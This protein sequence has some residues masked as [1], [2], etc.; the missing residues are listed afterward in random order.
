MVRTM[1]RSAFAFIAA[2]VVSGACGSHPTQPQAPQVPSNTAPP[3][4]PPAMPPAVKGVLAWPVAA[5]TKIQTKEVRDCDL[6]AVTDKRYPKTMGLDAL[7]GAYKVTSTCDQAVLAAACGVRLGED[8]EP[9]AACLDA[10]RATISA[11]P[12]FT[13]ANELIGAYWT[14]VQVAAPPITQHP[15]VS[16][17]LD[18]EWG[19]LGTAVKWTLTANDLTTKPSIAMTGPDKKAVVWSDDLGTMVA[20]LGGA[21]TSFLPVPKP[22]QAVDCTDNYPQWTATMVFDDGTKLELST[23]GSNLLGLGGPWQM[24]VGGVHYLQLGSTFVLAI[25]KVIEK[26]ALP[27]GEPMG[28]TCMGYDLQAEVFGPP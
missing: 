22:L 6:A 7:A 27:I 4:T 8:A 3:A 24:T 1:S 12:A 16:V 13:F 17:V 5:F 28:S 2:L 10:Y 19:G 11:N 26:L 18:Y 21:L 25:D 15:L 14:Q 20:A 23:E 9:P